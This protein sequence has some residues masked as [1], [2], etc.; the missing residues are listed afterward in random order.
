MIPSDVTRRQRRRSGRRR[1]HTRQCWQC[2]PLAIPTISE[3]RETN[4]HVI[5]IANQKGGVGKTVTAF[6]LANALF[7]LE[8]EVEQ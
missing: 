6:H 4:M 5:A 3:K 1:W 8:C 7:D 2:Q